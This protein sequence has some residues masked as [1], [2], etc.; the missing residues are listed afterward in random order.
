ME[1]PDL[2][3]PGCGQR[4]L[5]LQGRLAASPLGSFSLAGVQTK[6]TAKAVTYLVC[7]SCGI[8]SQESA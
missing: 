5:Q 8:E 2:A 4:A 1:V 6:V 7:T 3:C